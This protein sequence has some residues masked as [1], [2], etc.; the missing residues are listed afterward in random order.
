MFLVSFLSIA[1]QHAVACKARYCFTVS[2]R[3]SAHPRGAQCQYC[4][5]TI[6]H[7]V[8]LFLPSV[9]LSF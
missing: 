3:L 7:I 6:V 2:V 9:R 5:A 4:I 1:R 8:K